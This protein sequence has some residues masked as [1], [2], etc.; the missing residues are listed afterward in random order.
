MSV[1]IFYFPDGKM[2]GDIDNIIKPILD[3]MSAHI[4]IDDSQEIG[5][6]HV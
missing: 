2:D 3:A 5:R 4:Y 6:A 1:T